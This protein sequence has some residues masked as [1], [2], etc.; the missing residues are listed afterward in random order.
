MKPDTAWLVSNSGR[1]LTARRVLLPLPGLLGFLLDGI[2]IN[3]MVNSPKGPAIFWEVV[4][5][6]VAFVVALLYAAMFKT[7]IFVGLPV[8]VAAIFFPSRSLP[9]LGFLGHWLVY[10]LG[11]M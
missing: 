5:A 11:P 7:R 10:H 3:I 1:R 4:Y 8:L 6:A 2:S 9:V